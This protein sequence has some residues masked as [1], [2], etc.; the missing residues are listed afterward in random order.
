MEKIAIGYAKRAKKMNMRQLKAIEWELL[1]TRLLIRDI[2]E[3]DV[4]SKDI[5]PKSAEPTD[6]T[7][8]IRQNLTGSTKFSK[9][10][11]ELFSS[12]M[13]PPQVLK[14]L[15]LILIS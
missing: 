15:K 14:F 13:M 10:Y 12:K 4:A 6:S 9:L 1:T 8:D 5:D 7:D 3:N 11:R 2:N